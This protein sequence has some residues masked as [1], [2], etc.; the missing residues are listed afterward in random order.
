MAGTIIAGAI[1]A[2]TLTHS[3]AGS[4]ATNYLRQGTKVW[5]RFN[6]DTPAITDSFNVSSVDDVTTGEY[7][8]NFSSAMSSA[9]AFAV[10]ANSQNEAS[11]SDSCNYPMSSDVTASRCSITCI[12]GNSPRDKGNNHY[13]ISGELA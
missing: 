5:L 4:I 8:P 3:T 12:E 7:R 9:N 1:T 2:D 13:S 11:N 6:Q 10:N